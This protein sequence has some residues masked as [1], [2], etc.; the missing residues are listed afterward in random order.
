MNH[1]HQIDWQLKFSEGLIG[2]ITQWNAQKGFGFVYVEDAKTDVFFRHHVFI[3]NRTQPKVGDKVIVCAERDGMGWRAMS[4]YLPDWGNFKNAYNQYDT[5]TLDVQLQ[6]RLN[7]GVVGK[8]INWN[9][10][11]GLGMIQIF[12]PAMA[13]AFQI[14][15]FSLKSRAP[16]VGESVYVSVRHD[17]FC[18]SATAVTPLIKN[19][20]IVKIQEQFRPLYCPMVKPLC[21]AVMGGLAWWL[22]L[23]GWN[24]PIWWVSMILSVV[25]FFVYAW[26][27]YCE[28]EHRPT[29]HALFLHV[30]D[31]LGGW[32]GSMV[33]RY[34]F[35]HRVERDFSR[36]FWV[37]VVLN[38]VGCAWL[39]NIFFQAA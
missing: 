25:M 27:K 18:W 20:Y 26:D 33:A 31:A 34:L 21:V 37:L 16:V 7:K 2:I 13:I 8:I 28:I 9:E 17:G 19:E 30:G 14:A 22:V 23:I 36:W 4:V 11:L 12:H 10:H 35:T 5:P 1:N 24:K 32:V 3:A 29:I 15:A 38:M 39:A 6:E